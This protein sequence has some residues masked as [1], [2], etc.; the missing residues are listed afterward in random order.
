MLRRI[1]VQQGRG[2]RRRGG[3]GRVLREE[4]TL[5]SVLSGF[6]R[7]SGIVSYAMKAIYWYVRI[8]MMAFLAVDN[9]MS[10]PSPRTN[11]I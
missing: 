6:A 7:A 2:R 8:E 3:G 11:N 5:Y 1:L 4:E 9:V 10:T